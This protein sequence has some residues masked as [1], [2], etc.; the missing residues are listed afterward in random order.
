LKAE[1]CRNG[2]LESA[3]RKVELFIRLMEERN[4]VVLSRNG[5]SS[6]SYTGNGN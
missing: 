3:G 1:V 6:S 4:I 5:K 2:S